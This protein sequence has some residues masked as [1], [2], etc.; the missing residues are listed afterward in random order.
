MGSVGGIVAVALGLI[1]MALGGLALA[2]S[3]AHRL[4]A[5]RTVSAS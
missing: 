2:R 5:V 1:G 4:T 3:R